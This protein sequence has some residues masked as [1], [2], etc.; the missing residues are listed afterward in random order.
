MKITRSKDV[1]FQPGVV[2]GK[3]SNTRKGLSP[4]DAKLAAGMWELPAGKRSFPM[5]KHN[6]TEE[7]LFVISGTAKVRTPDGETAIGPGDWVTFPAGGLAHQLEN[8][9]TETLVYLGL[10]TNPV[11]VDVVEYPDSE[12]I[13]AVMGAPPTGRRFTFRTK[14]TVDYFE[15]EE[16]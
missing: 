9:G 13:G 2:R 4:P 16:S 11:G 7:A 8:D 14:D 12:K 3:F 1:P 10:S 15:G 5:H 6:V